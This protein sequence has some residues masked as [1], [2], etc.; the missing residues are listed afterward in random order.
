MTFFV[1][2]T[3]SCFLLSLTYLLQANYVKTHGLGGS[4]VWAMDL[5]DFNGA[6]GLGNNPLMSKLKEVLSDPNMVLTFVLG[7]ESGILLVSEM[8]IQLQVG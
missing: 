3:F 7:S 1:G 6:C 5:D 8:E 4:M 2:N